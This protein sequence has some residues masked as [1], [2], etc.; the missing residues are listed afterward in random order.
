MPAAA[1]P[2][3]P[4]DAPADA[5][6]FRHYVETTLDALRA[7]P[8]R[9]VLVHHERRVTA[10]EFRDL[11]HRLARALEERGI[12]R[13]QTVTL[14]SGNLPEAIAVRYAANLLGC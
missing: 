12:G 11:V 4:V 7:E 1:A 14:L 13:G 10:R 8:D 6:G 9:E 2:T 5:G 3:M